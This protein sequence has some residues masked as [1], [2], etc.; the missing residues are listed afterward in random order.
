VQIRILRGA[1]AG[2]ILEFE[3]DTI[4]VGRDAEADLRFDPS[5][6]LDVS[7][8]HALLFRNGDVWFVRDLDSRNG[9]LLNG[10]RVSEDRQLADGDR[11]DFGADGPRVD[12]WMG[13][14][15]P[16]ASRTEVLRAQVQRQRRALRMVL[17]GAGV[18][19]ALLSVSLIMVSRAGREQQAAAERERQTLLASIDSQLAATEGALASLRGE[20]DSLALALRESEARVRASRSALERVSPGDGPEDEL[21]RQLRSATEALSL[22]Q[23]AASIDFR[24]IERDNRPA[25]AL[26]FVESED[27]EVATATAFAVRRDGTLVTVRHVLTGVDGTRA[28]RRIAVQFSDS[29]QFFPARIVAVAQDADLA[30]VRTDAVDGDVPVI[31]GFVSDTESGASGQPVAVIGFPLGG[32]TAFGRVGQAVARPLTT[33]GIILSATNDR[34]EMQGYGA[35]GASGSPVFD[36]HGRVAAVLVGGRPNARDSLVAVP[37][38][39][40]VRLLARVR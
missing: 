31:R 3:A 40:A 32:E 16:P 10:T 25:V 6:D 7:A 19:V 29:E 23:L 27:G 22:Q 2:A 24:A 36:A 14:A 9:T 35:A 8:R 37:A 20:M 28:P 21:R 33:A 1:Q 12:V 39:T 4:R 17:I 30:I 5:R 15:P 34:L 13:S 26:V 18:A 11:L 38:A